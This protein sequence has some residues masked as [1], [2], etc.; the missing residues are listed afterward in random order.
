MR[1]KLATDDLVNERACLG[2]AGIDDLP[3]HVSSRPATS[4]KTLMLKNGEMLRDVGPAN[5]GELCEL[6]GAAALLTEQV[7][8]LVPGRIGEG[9]KDGGM[10][11]VAL[12]FVVHDCA[13]AELRK[14]E[15]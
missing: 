14:C 1:P 5:T 8:E 7:E 15:T 2:K 3:H 12:S 6:A 13:I 10:D 4:R 9:R 11:R